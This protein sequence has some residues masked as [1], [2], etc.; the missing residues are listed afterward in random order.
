[1]AFSRS[2]ATRSSKLSGS[3][4]L[5]ALSVVA[6]LVDGGQHKM[7]SHGQ[8]FCSRDPHKNLDLMV[9]E[10]VASATMTSVVEKAVS[11]SKISSVVPLVKSLSSIC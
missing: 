4:V 8:K 7:F 5:S 11:S 9:V 1:M 6:T 2:N 10:A 3:S